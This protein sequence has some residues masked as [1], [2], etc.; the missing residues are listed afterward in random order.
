Q[1]FDAVPAQGGGV[2]EDVLAGGFGTDEAI[3]AFGVV[4][5]HLAHDVLAVGR[6][7]LGRR[8]A[9]ALGAPHRTSRRQLDADDAHDLH[10]LPAAARRGS[11]CRAPPAATR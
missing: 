5:L 8:L 2:D 10:A 11:H 3:A 1:A 9:R 4:P 7:G 6:C